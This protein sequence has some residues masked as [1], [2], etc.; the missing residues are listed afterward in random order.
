MIYINIYIYNY[1]IVPVG[2]IISTHWLPPTAGN[3]SAILSA[4]VTLHIATLSF[5]VAAGLIGAM[6]TKGRNYSPGGW[7]FSWV[8]S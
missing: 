5:N 4:G 8:E 2:Y 1:I 6:E 3:A 7:S